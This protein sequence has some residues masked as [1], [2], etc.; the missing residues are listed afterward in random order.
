MLRRTL[1]AVVVC[2]IC[3]CT[4]DAEPNE[5]QPAPTTYGYEVVNTYPHDKSAFCQGLAFADGFLFEGTGQ[6]GESSVRK[7][8]IESGRVVQ[9]LMLHRNYFGEGI[10]IFGNDILLLT[11]RSQ[12]GFVLDKQTFEQKSAF[13]YAGEGWG[14]T[15]DGKRLIVSDGTAV[16]RFLDPKTFRV[17]GRL[18]VR[19]RGRPVT[20]LNELEYVEGEIYANVF[21]TDYIVRIAPDTG[22][23]TG[24]IDLRGLIGRRERSHIDAVLNGIAYDPAKK[25]LFVTGKDWPKLFEIRVVEK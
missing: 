25:R 13:R 7:V 22:A 15:H 4:S 3:G 14:I 17:V 19:S 20:N 16:L 9:R 21:E 24:W 8:D 1:V 18:T 5:Q 23:V 11:W 6:Y 2:S 10:T 12:T